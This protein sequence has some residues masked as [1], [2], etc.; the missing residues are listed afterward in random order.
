MRG[1]NHQRALEMEARRRREEADALLLNQQRAASR[2]QSPDRRS[3]IF[4]D[5]ASG[6]GGSLNRRCLN[7]YWLDIVDQI[8]PLPD[9]AVPAAVVC[10]VAPK[11]EPSWDWKAELARIEVEVAAFLIGSFPAFP[12]WSFSIQL[13]LPNIG[14]GLHFV[15]SICSLL[16]GP[17]PSQV[18]SFL[19]GVNNAYG[20]GHFA[21]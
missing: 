11:W 20:F 21:G 10:S 1:D 15:S 19:D 17:L 2:R 4:F 12:F 18:A 7:G 13:Q 3:L 8:C 5:G 14:F 16:D 6:G 9:E